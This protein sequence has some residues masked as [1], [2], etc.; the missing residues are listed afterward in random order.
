MEFARWAGWHV[1]EGKRG[2]ALV[3]AESLR[4]MHTPIVSMAPRP[5]AAVGTPAQGRYGL[6]WAE[7]QLP[8]YPEPF[9]F[10]GGSNQLNLAYIMLLPRRDYALVLVTNVGGDKADAAL[11]ALVKELIDGWPPP[12]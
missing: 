10:H 11:K 1:G 2:P 7:V 12:A 9:V 4:R 6:G 5:D 8:F 3:S